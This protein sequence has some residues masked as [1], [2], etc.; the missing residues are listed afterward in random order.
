MKTAV[1][2]NTPKRKVSR[3]LALLCGMLLTAIPV[4]AVIT[5]SAKLNSGRT[6]ILPVDISRTQ[7]Q[8][9]VPMIDVSVFI[10]DITLS[11]I[12][13]DDYFSAGDKV[14]VFMRNTGGVWYP[15]AV[16]RSLPEGGENLREDQIMI[17]GLVSAAKDGKIKIAYDFDRIAPRRD[18]A[19]A[20]LRRA[21]Q[22]TQ[23]ELVIGNDGSAVVSAL[24]LDGKRYSQ[25]PSLKPVLDGF[26]INTAI[27]APPR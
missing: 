15:Y 21:G 11:G 25:R 6:I 14:H 3:G 1:I 16:L 23:L 4:G 27:K 13:G 7:V 8:T 24:S 17:T 19:R 10:Q 5:H 20:A 26:N 22:T 2:Y 12:S 18:F 9:I